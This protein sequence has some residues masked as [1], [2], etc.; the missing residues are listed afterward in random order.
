MPR[1]IL[2]RLAGAIVSLWIVVTATFFA[3]HFLPGDP[4][5]AA[6]SQ[7]TVSQDVL[8]RRREALGLDRPLASQYVHYLGEVVQFRFGISWVTGESVAQMISSQIWATLFLAVTGMGI[9][10]AVGLIIGYLA[11]GVEGEAIEQI[12]RSLNG[13]LLG[14]PPAF[15]GTFLIWIFAILL[16][17]LPATGQ[18][19]IQTL[20][21]P[22]ITVGIST[23]GGIAQSI[24]AG[25]H[26]IR[27]QPFLRTAQ[28]KGLTFRQA[29]WRHGIR[30]AILPTL[31]IAAVQFGYLL[32]GTLIV[33]MVF[34]RQGLG[35]LILSAVLNQ[36]L[37]VVQAAVILV[38]V[39]YIVLNACAEVVHAVLD[40][41]V[42]VTL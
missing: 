3:V 8:D 10:L 7:S 26:D 33:E 17:W 36:D 20:I 11:S 35:R 25:L 42:R 1:L 31:S 15:S 37:P 2:Q 41:R 21:L 16:G 28:A 27:D 40:P 13:F 6:L 5:E 34:A 19:G 29:V 39:N 38:C 18:E 30:I 9:A 4:A 12:S 22:A 23:S 32:S 14:I 24:Q